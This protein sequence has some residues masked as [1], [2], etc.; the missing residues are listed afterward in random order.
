[1]RLRGGCAQ[2]AGA[3]PAEVDGRGCCPCMGDLLVGEV[4]NVS[5]REALV[6]LG[7]GTGTPQAVH[8]SGRLFV[9]VGSYACSTLVRQGVESVFEAGMCLVKVVRIHYPSTNVG[10][11]PHPFTD[12]LRTSQ[13]PHAETCTPN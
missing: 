6:S 8:E 2:V 7:Y 1:M 3:A 12:Y 4:L 13:M 5:L 11:R 9:R 10:G